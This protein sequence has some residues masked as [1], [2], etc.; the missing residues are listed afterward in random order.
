MIWNEHSGKVLYIIY[1]AVC[2]NS[3]DMVFVKLHFARQSSQKI[4]IIE[5]V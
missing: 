5:L 1:H 2:I 4:E 3:I